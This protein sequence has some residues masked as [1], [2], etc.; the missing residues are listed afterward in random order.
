M[1]FMLTVP[2]IALPFL[3]VWVFINKGWNGKEITIKAQIDKQ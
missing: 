2:T 1:T 3:L